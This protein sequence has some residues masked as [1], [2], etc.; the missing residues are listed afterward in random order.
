MLL[1]KENLLDKLLVNLDF[2]FRQKILEM[3]RKL[4]ALN[5]SFSM[6]VFIAICFDSNK[7]VEPGRTTTKF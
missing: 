4:F 7:L 1:R 2:L 6:A 5:I 3:F